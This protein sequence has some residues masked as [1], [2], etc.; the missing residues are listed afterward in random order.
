[1]K[2]P[3]EEGGWGISS[4][5]ASEMGPSPSGDPERFLNR[6]DMIRHQREGFRLKQ[7]DGLRSDRLGHDSPCGRLLHDQ[8]PSGVVELEKLVDSHPALISR[9]ATFPASICFKDMA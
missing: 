3:T 9:P 1:M 4:A 7:I 6:R 8:F 2:S 5:S